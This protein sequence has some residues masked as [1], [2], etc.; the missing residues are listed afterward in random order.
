[1]GECS[2]KVVEPAHAGTRKVEE[3]MCFLFNCGGKNVEKYVFWL[4]WPPE[5]E[6]MATGAQNPQKTHS[7]F[8]CLLETFV[9]FLGRSF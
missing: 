9:V 3:I 5:G 4:K 1:M 7:N 6:K 8:E 2:G